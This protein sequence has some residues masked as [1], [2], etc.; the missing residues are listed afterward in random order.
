MSTLLSL[1][2]I[3]SLFA[4]TS[5]EWFRRNREVAFT[6][7][8]LRKHDDGKTKVHGEELWNGKT[9]F[10]TSNMSA[11]VYES[12][13]FTGT[14]VMDASG[15]LVADTTTVNTAARE[16]VNDATLVSLFSSAT[17]SA[18]NAFIKHESSG[19]TFYKSM[20]VAGKWIFRAATSIDKM[21]DSVCVLT[22]LAQFTPEF[23]A[24]W[25]DSQLNGKGFSDDGLVIHCMLTKAGSLTPSFRLDTSGSYASDSNCVQ[26]VRV[27]TKGTFNATRD[28]DWAGKPRVV[29]EY[30][31]QCDCDS[32][33]LPDS[34]SGCNKLAFSDMFIS[35]PVHCRADDAD[36]KMQFGTPDC[37]SPENKIKYVS[38]YTSH[39]SEYKGTTWWDEHDDLWPEASVSF[40]VYSG[41]QISV[42]A[43]PFITTS[44]SGSNVTCRRVQEYRLFGADETVA[45]L[46]SRFYQSI[47]HPSPY[48][49]CKED[50]C[51]AAD[52][53]D[54]TLSPTDNSTASTIDAALMVL[55]L[56]SVLFAIM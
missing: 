33:S 17:T 35:A 19:K 21:R 54:A 10:W 40:Q 38:L 37:T 16:L 39:G 28:V 48:Y 52:F 55:V 34:K 14:K 13:Y 7:V 3:S 5:G 11:D 47:A 44:K 31:M 56:V 6:R 45:K 32:A 1:I 8:Q 9:I 43:M 4:S 25:R 29:T 2:A 53:L 41:K 24:W 42:I 15:T 27:F 30:T 46:S 51:T 49:E 20:S 50:A 18:T 26:G 23:V 12:Q 36:W 22:T